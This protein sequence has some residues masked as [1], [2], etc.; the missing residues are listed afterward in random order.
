M[1]IIQKRKFIIK[2]LAL[3]ISVFAAFFMSGQVSAYRF[4]PDLSPTGE[5]DIGSVANTSVILLPSKMG[6]TD[7]VITMEG[8]NKNQFETRKTSG[9]YTIGDGEDTSCKSFAWKGPNRNNRISAGTYSNIDMRVTFKFSKAARAIED[10]AWYDVY[11]TVTD[12]NIRIGS[13]K[14]Y[15]VP[16]MYGCGG[17][18]NFGAFAFASEGG[19]IGVKYDVSVVLKKAGTN[20]V[21]SNVKGNTHKMIWGFHDVDI[22]D[23]FSLCPWGLRV[24]A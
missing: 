11:V 18:F 6:F 19:T 10:G 12:L 16:T 13:K 7:A 5:W 8:S 23:R 17:W 3:I 14:K 9:N 24:L 2:T 4:S 1:K 20:T 21:I 22:A 15:G